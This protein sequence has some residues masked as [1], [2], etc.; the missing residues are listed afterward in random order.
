LFR[1]V[2]VF[3]RHLTPPPPLKRVFCQDYNGAFRFKGGRGCSLRYLQLETIKIVKILNWGAGPPRA[4]RGPGANVFY[5]PYI[6]FFSG[7]N[8]FR[9]TTIPP[10]P[11]PKFRYFTQKNKYLALGPNKNFLG[12]PV[13]AWR[14]INLFTGT[15]E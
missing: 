10:P 4:W 13:G 2:S 5:G 14:Q 11:P 15:H 9:T 1:F 12:G 3:W 8:V 6:K 7:K